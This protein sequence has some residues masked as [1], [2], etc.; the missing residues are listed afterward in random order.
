M[1]RGS[2]PETTLFNHRLERREPQITDL[3]VPWGYQRI[4]IQLRREGW[5]VSRKRVY[6]LYR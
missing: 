5:M 1:F 3:H 2:A 4:E 6:R